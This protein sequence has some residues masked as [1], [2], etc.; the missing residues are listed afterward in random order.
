MMRASILLCFTL[1]T[2]AVSA[3]AVFRAEVSAESVRTGEVVEISFRVEGG[4]LSRFSAPDFSPFTIV[5]GPSR[6]QNFSMVNGKV[7]RSVI[8]SYA[9]RAT[10]QGTFTLAG[11][12]GEVDGKIRT[13]NPVS[14][15][16]EGGDNQDTPA[17]TSEGPA[18]GDL[19]LVVSADKQN[20]W[21]GEQIILTYKLYYRI[22]FENVQIVQSPSYE[23]FLMHDFGIGQ[24][25]ERIES[26]RGNATIPYYSARW[27]YS[28]PKAAPY[29]FHPSNWSVPYSKEG[30]AFSAH[31]GRIALS[32][33]PTP[34]ILLYVPCLP[35]AVLLI[36]PG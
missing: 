31:R 4:N 26:Y 2:M 11:A 24:P 8:I 23:G 28:R 29:L 16:V 36:F 18:R 34:S 32:F 20:V 5:S 21:E 27:P 22:N 25:Q 33:A 17:E 19:F 12:T 35:R 6:V 9:L 1:F 15:T 10:R 30:V 7:S 3:D 13:F 14:I